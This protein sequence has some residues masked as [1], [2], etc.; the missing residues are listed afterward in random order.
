MK[1]VQY[2]DTYWKYLWRNT[3]TYWMFVT[4]VLIAIIL[5]Y[6][7]VTNFH[8]REVF[9]FLFILGGIGLTLCVS[10]WKEY[11]HY[12]KRERDAEIRD[13]EM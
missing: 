8:S 7:F 5:G 11:K 10:C 6:I 3:K 13:K 9:V 12:R 1:Q 2:N 4:V